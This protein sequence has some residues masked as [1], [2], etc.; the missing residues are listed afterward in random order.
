MQARAFH[1]VAAFWQRV[2]D[3]LAQQEVCNGLMMGL[4]L[5]LID[6]PDY[7][8]DELFMVTVDEG[9]ELRLVAL[10]TPPHKLILA[11][12]HLLLT[13]E[14]ILRLIQ[15][16]REND[17]SLPGVVA[18]AELASRFA[19]AWQAA[20]GQ[21]YAVEMEQGVY[22]LREVTHPD[23]GRGRLRLA[24]ASDAPLVLEWFR[25]F[26]MDTFGTVREEKD[27][28]PQVERSVGA[29]RVYLWELDDG[30]VV[31]MAARARPTEKGMTVNMVYTPP[32]LRRQGYATACVAKLSQV[33]LDEGYEY[34]TLFTD[35]AN[36]TS[37]A[38]YRRMGYRYVCDFRSLNFAS[39]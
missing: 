38:I 36:P 20:T 8:G 31:S 24:T 32:E 29:G 7:Y 27:V 2:C 23:Y 3:Y 13:G 6:Q 11:S 15:Y 34:C 19:A 22:E 9:E 16:V 37:N 28:L 30:Q 17:I 1:D 25:A 5:R 4:I 35:L 10:M 18:P 26:E 12:N 14:S 21:G 33:L 39:D